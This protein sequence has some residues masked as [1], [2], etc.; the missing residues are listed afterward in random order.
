MKSRNAAA[1]VLIF[2]FILLILAVFMQPAQQKSSSSASRRY[3]VSSSEAHYSPLHTPRP[4]TN[5]TPRATARPNGTRRSV[6]PELST[7]DFTHPE[8]FY[9]WNRDDFSDYEEAE[10]YYYSHGGR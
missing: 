6:L 10:D 1:F 4:T 2:V 8:D 5:P 7:D 3:P 9:D